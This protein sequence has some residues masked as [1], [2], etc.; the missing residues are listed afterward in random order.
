MFAS[1]FTRG[2]RLI[3]QLPRLK[4]VTTPQFQLKSFMSTEIRKAIDEAVAKTPVVL[5]MKGTP[6][7]PL[8]GF[9]RA[10]ITLLGKQG[11]DPAKFA[12][13]DVLED[14]EL[15]EAIKEYTDWPTIPQLFVNGEFIGGCDIVVSMAKSGELAELLENANVLVDADADT[16]AKAGTEAENNE[17]EA[18]ET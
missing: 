17:K 1:R 14:P 9:S 13:Y 2:A 15:R 6:E 16:A 7:F 8:C 18:K 4:P 10:T 3:T 12:A 11:V 5:F